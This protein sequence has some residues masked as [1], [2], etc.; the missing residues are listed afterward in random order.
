MSDPMQNA[1]SPGPTRPSGTT[2]DDGQTSDSSP[3]LVLGGSNELELDSIAGGG[4]RRHVRQKSIG[5]YSFNSDC[6]DVP[7]LNVE[8]DGLPQVDDALLGENDGVAFEDGA[9]PAGPS[10]SSEGML[11]ICN[12]FLAKSRKRGSIRTSYSRILDV[13]H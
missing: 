1:T 11:F 4:V 10:M 12:L 2:P 3:G 6:G 8:S 5:S 9:G 7:L 13:A